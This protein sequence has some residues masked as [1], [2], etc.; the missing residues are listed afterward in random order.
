MR[1]RALC[2][3]VIR[4]AFALLAGIGPVSAQDAAPVAEVHSADAPAAEAPPDPP[5]KQSTLKKVRTFIKEK[6]AAFSGKPKDGFYP[7]IGG[8][9]TGSGLAGGAGYRTHLTGDVLIDVS[10]VISTKNY[11]GVDLKGRWAAFWND[12]VELW[13]LFEYRDLTQEDFYGLGLDSSGEARVN[14]AM[15]TTD[16]GGRVVTHVFPWLNAGVD[17]G[18]HKPR[19]GPGRDP[20]FLT[21]GDRFP[22]AEAPG[23]LAQPVFLCNTIFVEA[24]YRDT[25]GNPHR[26]G[27]VRASFGKW[28]DRTLEQFDFHRFDAQ[29][30]HFIPLAPKHVVALHMGLA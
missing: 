15:T 28:D 7:R 20:K 6:Q 3:V 29:A 16:I 27:Y 19:I 9:V 2:H 26:G 12:R 10:G 18:R 21:I 5:P 1:D 23:L 17:V 14:Y 30:A 25:P 13:T 22:D 8:L 24:D 11:K 4:A